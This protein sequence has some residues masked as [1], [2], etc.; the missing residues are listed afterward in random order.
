MPRRRNFLVQRRSCS[1]KLQ[2]EGLEPRMMLAADSIVINELHVNPDIDTEL[3]E[4]VELHN[5]SD[6]EVTLDGWYFDDGISYAFPNDAKIAPGGFHVITQNA[7]HFVEKFGMP[8]NGQW[9]GRLSNQG[10][11]VALRTNTGELVDRVDYGLG[12]PW[13]TVGD[14]PGYS[15]ELVNT[16]LDNQLGGSWR[17]STGDQ[18]VFDFGAPWQYFKGTEEPNADWRANNFD[19]SSWSVGSTPIGFGR[20]VAASTELDDMRRNY[21]TVYLRREF[22]VDDPASANSLAFDVLYDDGINVW[23]NGTHVAGRNVESENVPF[24]ALATGNGSTRST[25]LIPLENASEYLVAGTNTIAVQLLNATLSG[26]DAVLNAALLNLSLPAPG[27][28][29]FAV[30][31]VVA[32]N[33]GPQMRQV[34]HVPA[35]PSSTDDVTITMKATD[36]D[37]VASVNLEYQ[38]VAAGDYI[39]IGDSRF[40]TEWTS[41]PMLDDGTNGDALAGDSIY[42]ATVRADVHQHRQLM[43]YRVRA[44]DQAGEIAVAPTADDPQPNFAYF[45]YDGI[46]S[47][48]GADRPGRTESVTFGEDVMNQLAT[49]HL[50]A[51]AGDVQRSQYQSAFEQVRFRG[52]MVYG[53]E[54][55]DHIEFRIRGEFSTY[56]AGKNKWKFFFNRGHEFQGHDNFGRPFA[57]KRRVLN[58]SGATTPWMPMNRGMAGLGEATAYRLYDLAGI[59]SPDTNYVQFRVIDE[60]E[61]SPED[62][63]D[64][65]L[66]GLYLVLEHPDGRFLGERGLPDGTTFKME[67]GSGQGDIKNQGPTQPDAA[68]T[69]RTFMTAANRRTNDEQFWRDNVDLDSYYTFRAINREVNNMDIR[70]GWNH[71]MYHNPETNKFTVIPW[72]LD[73]LYIPTTHWS[74]V[75]RLENLLRIDALDIEYRNRGRE[76]QDLLFNAEQVGMLVDEIAGVV[77]PQTGNM[78]MVDVDQFMWNNNPATAGNHRRAFNR[79]T[80]RYDSRGG[81]G[82]RTMVSGDH[83][84]FAQWIKDFMLPAPGGG[85]EPAAYGWNFLERESRDSDIPETPSLT[86]VVDADSTLDVDQ[87]RFSVSQF[88]DPQG[89]ETF[90]G[91]EWRLAEVVDPNAPSH[92]PTAPNVYEVETTWESGVQD[93][94]NNEISVPAN[95]ATPGRAYRARVR[96]F[97]DTGRASHWSEPIHFIASASSTTDLA[98]KLRVSEVHYHPADPTP[99]EVAAGFTDKNDFEFVELENIS[100]AAIDLSSVQLTQVDVEGSS[101]GVEFNFAEGAITQL[102]AGQRVV[103]VENAEAFAARYGDGIPVAGAWSGR[104]SNSAETLTLTGAGVQIQ[105]FRY[106]D[107]WYPSTDGEGRSLEIAN[108]GGALE[109]WGDRRGW[110]ASSAVGGSPGES[111]RIVGDSNGDGIFNS[112]DLVLVFAAAEYEDDIENN[113]TF[114]TGDWDGDGDFTTSDFVFAFRA[115]RYSA[116]AKPLQADSVDLLFERTEQDDRLLKKRRP[117]LA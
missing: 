55:Y 62:Q 99:E 70:D 63:Y 92:D 48:T 103:V 83:E 73:M 107:D 100:G 15:M 109:D 50:I 18:L 11:T 23:I 97:D 66:W 117:F 72:D 53:D 4:F 80:A 113:S 42:T 47:S 104:L 31:S 7:D 33:L 1:P 26:S 78:T 37:G 44:T 32:S 74:G 9:E 110:Q 69:L 38:V 71:Y 43:R 77:N 64:G 76:L 2:T 30:N 27:P 52:T 112:S 95:A 56:V 41:I 85:S 79:Q 68:R 51:D 111:P 20:T 14:E 91:M 39:R 13:P 65:D 57:E 87:M 10:E 81:A 84:G 101:E 96:V 24:D 115:G 94:F 75:I 16:N 29:P 114:E 108:V 8:A 90:G 88:A 22:Q 58:F 61:E 116:A 86:H 98:D 19:D 46:P 105:Q 34:S 60:V 3:V 89:A 25:E 59:A 12:F 54:V 102:D 67:G 28:T 6:Q 93:V 17:P 49:Y 21:S 35:Q 82:S 40:S 36:P 106:M 45:V 5:T